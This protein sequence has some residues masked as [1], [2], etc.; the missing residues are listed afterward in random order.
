[1]SNAVEELLRQPGIWRA[2]SA[3]T[4]A[5]GRHVAT[6]IPALDEALP[7]GG[8]PCGALTEILHDRDGIG[9]LSLVLPALAELSEG[10]GW[11]AFIAPPWL[12]YAPA[13]AAAGVALSRVLLIHPRRDTDTLWAVEQALRAGTCGAV[14]A[15]PRQ[16]D[17]TSLRRLQLAAEA[18]DSMGLLF[19]RG[20]SADRA[21]PAA[22]RLHLG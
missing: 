10:G 9:E 13:L 5:G 4:G 17:G 18:G 15:W 21:S 8:W 11:V 3:E 6:G 14:L 12:P 19:R 22:L 16:V 1:M 7:R 2:G 20:D